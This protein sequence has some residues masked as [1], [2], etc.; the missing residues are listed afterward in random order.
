MNEKMIQI[1][2]VSAGLMYGY[3]EGTAQPVSCLA[4]VD[5]GNGEIKIQVMGITNNELFKEVMEN[6]AVVFKDGM[7]H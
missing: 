6:G 3:D 5:I 2:P 4:L 7:Q 1:I